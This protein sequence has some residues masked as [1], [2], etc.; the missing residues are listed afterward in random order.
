MN[1]RIILLAYKIFAGISIAVALNL[2]INSERIYVFT[3][4][5][6]NM[7]T[8]CLSHLFRSSLVS[9]IHILQFS[10]CKFYTSFGKFIPKCFFE[11]L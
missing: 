5:S 9:S 7:N 1:F 11:F 4:L 10:A 6:A 8:A 2:C 3:A